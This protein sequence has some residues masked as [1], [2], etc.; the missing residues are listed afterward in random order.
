MSKYKKALLLAI[1][2]LMPF[3]G[4]AP[5]A[6][7]ATATADVDVGVVA[8]A[9]G[10]DETVQLESVI[11]TIINVVLGL[12]GVILLII[13]IYSG[14]LWMTAGGKSEQVD[15]AKAWLINAV[16]G[17]V[18]ILAAYA[19]SSFVIAALTEAGLATGA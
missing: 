12:L 16:I 1:I 6:L 19:I 3:L 8:G 17:L 11:G 10:Y 7:G 14:F 18:L 13:V 9:A 4:F 15:K 2:G 5:V